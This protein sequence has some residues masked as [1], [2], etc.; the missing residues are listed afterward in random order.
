MDCFWWEIVKC[1]LVLKKHEDARWLTREQ[2]GN[3][4][5]LSVNVTLIEKI[6]FLM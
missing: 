3:V 2:L 1:N 4:E 6:S 5:Y